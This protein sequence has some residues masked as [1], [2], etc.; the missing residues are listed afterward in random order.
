DQRFW[1]HPGVDLLAIARAIWQNA[2]SGRR[3]SGASTIAMQVARMQ[4]PGARTYYHKAVEALTALFLTARYGREAVLK[5][6]MRIVPYGNR[7]HG[8]AY[9]AR[10][11]LDKPLDDLS[12]A[13]IAL[14]SAI[15]QAPGRMNPFNPRG[16]IQARKRGMRMLGLLHEKGLIS[17]EAWE[18]ARGQLARMRFPEKKKRRN[19]S[20]HAILKL[21][22]MLRAAASGGGRHAEG[23]VRTTLDL[24]IQDRVA[25]LSRLYLKKWRPNGAGN[26]AVIVTKRETMETLAW[27]GSADYFHS[28]A[29][30]MDYTRVIRSP[31]SALKPFVY[32]LALERGRI[33]PSSV[34]DDI[35]TAAMGVKN[36]DLNF[37][38]P[39]IPRQA[40]AN[41]RNVPAIQLTR[42]VGVDEVHLFLRSLGVHADEHAARYYGLCMSVGC[43]PTSLEKLVRAYGALA[44]DGLLRDFRWLRDQ[45]TGP[46]ARVLSQNTARQITLFLSDPMARLP[47]FP[48]MGS[49]E[50]PFPVAVKTGTS[51]GWRD[52]W[53]A[54]YSRDYMVGVW[55]GRPDHGPMNKLG[56]SRAAAKL[57]KRILLY[58]HPDQITGMAD[59][60]F[61]PPEGYTSAEISVYTGRRP[62]G[63]GEPTL[64]EW[65]PAGKLPKENQTGEIRRI[66]VRDSLLATPWTP[67]EMI[68]E[69]AFL[70]LPP[71]YIPW[72]RANN[73]PLPPTAYSP[74]DL[75]PGV[76]MDPAPRAVAP[77]TY[78]L[79][80]ETPIRLSID[81]PEDGLRLLTNPETPANRSSL[82]LRV[83]T[84]VSVPEILWCVDGQPY[85]LADPSR[86]VRWPLRSGAHTFQARL[87]FRDEMSK[88]VR[89][90]V[91]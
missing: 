33:T 89:I 2:G 69:R 32:A 48:R 9:A 53:A 34:L 57:A 25:L 79:K 72:A 31:G 46:P 12:W 61:P 52:A 45:E 63:A 16:R 26:I 5:H 13:E 81:S 56:G 67:G 39:M 55:V 50:Y 42:V 64:L 30:A 65:F 71:R 83:S 77:E 85:K 29:G 20:L 88:I 91:E 86:A 82:A 76:Q 62:V 17:G 6:Y 24:K 40:L 60:G 22:G 10:F 58:L 11:Y 41:S 8:I 78:S 18:L 73:I 4:A 75:P 21:Q 80:G 44:N 38:G 43:L 84:S 47:S 51:Q 23:L 15:P 87:P 36:A 49:T 19:N 68:R 90:I 66:D 54:V 74:M 14:L 1:K 27:L 3:V 37:L 70:H 35:Q 7:V 59:L 28:D